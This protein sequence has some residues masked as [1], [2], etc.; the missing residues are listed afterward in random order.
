MPAS[1]VPLL[2]ACATLTG[3]ELN[4]MLTLICKHMAASIGDDFVGNFA[5]YFDGCDWK[6]QCFEMVDCS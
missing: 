4:L 1:G 5:V 6:Q 3:A 2:H